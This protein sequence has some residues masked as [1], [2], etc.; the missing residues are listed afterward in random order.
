MLAEVT[1][2]THN[3]PHLVCFVN[4]T[5]LKVF[6]IIHFPMVLLI[7]KTLLFH[8]IKSAEVGVF[9]AY[10]EG[11]LQWVCALAGVNKCQQSDTGHKIWMW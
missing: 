5:V 6:N 4:T 8:L 11:Q 1:L 7:Q 10:L 2:V 3:N 9:Q